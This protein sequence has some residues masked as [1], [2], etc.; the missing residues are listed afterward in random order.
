MKK[1]TQL[2]KEERVRIFEGKKQHKTITAIAVDL[3]RNKATISREIKRN[4]DV[5]G[6]LYPEEAHY[7]TEKRK[8]R[9]GSKVRRIEGF[10]SYLLEK[11]DLY[12]S[13][14]EIVGRW[15]KGNPTKTIT[16][17]AVYAFVYS[18]EGKQ[19]ELYKKLTK[20]KRKRGIVRKQKQPKISESKNPIA[21]R[22]IEANLRLEVGH[23]EGDLIF[24]KGSMSANVLVLI[25]CKSR[26]VFLIKND[27]KES[28]PIMEMIQ[29]IVPF[30]QTITF[31]NGTEFSEFK[32]LEKY[33]ITVHFC[34][35]HS[36]W[37][38]GSVENANNLLRQFLSLVG[39]PYNL[40]NQKKLNEIAHT[41]NHTPRK[42]LNF[43]T[44]AEVFY[45]HFNQNYKNV[46][47]HI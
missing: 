9:H 34:N 28:R 3:G 35:P 10:F 23:L 14:I 44:P 20:K 2:S 46:A 21:N 43:L 17:E 18:K 26:F 27:S 45:H 40:I 39:M 47:L 13:P 33:G 16:P 25:D 8:A 1:Y 24:N 38:K 37:Q 15:N 32:M 11:L 6:Y 31:D 19:L 7:K 41:L 30:A 22:P 12:W 29:K 5:I 42:I 36:P 4:S